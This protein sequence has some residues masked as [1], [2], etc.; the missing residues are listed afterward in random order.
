[1]LYVYVYS[2]SD[3]LIKYP[4]VAV[5]ITQQQ[6]QRGGVDNVN[7]SPLYY[8]CPVKLVVKLNNVCAREQYTAPLKLRKTNYRALTKFHCRCYLWEVQNG[9]NVNSSKY[10]FHLIFHWKGIYYGLLYIKTCLGISI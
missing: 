9:E 1:M 10:I 3:Y 2:F 5:R 8:H 7:P 4:L 6:H